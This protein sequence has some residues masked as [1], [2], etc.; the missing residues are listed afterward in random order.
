MPRRHRAL[1]LLPA[2]LA[3]GCADQ[4]LQ[5]DADVRPDLAAV[6]SCGQRTNI[7]AS[8][9]LQCVTL[10]RVRMHQAELQAIADENG[11]M[12]VAGSAGYDASVAYVREQLEGAGYAVTTQ[13]FSFATTFSRTPS[14]LAQVS[15]PANPIAHSVLAYSGSGDHTAS[16]TVP[17]VATGCVAADWAGFPAGNIALVERGGSTNTFTCTFALK[18]ANAHAA[19]ARAVVIYNNTATDVAWTL[20]ADFTLD[21]PVVGVT[22]SSGQQLVATPGLELRVRTD[23]FRGMATASNVLAETST[24]NADNVVVVGAHLDG[25]AAGPGINDNGS[26]VGAVLETAIQMARVKPVNRVRFAF[27]GA[28]ESGLIGSEYYVDNL[29]VQQ[30]NQIALYLNFDVLGSPNH[31]FFIFDGDNSDGAGTGPGPA[32]SDQIEAVFEEY[33]DRLGRPHRGTP[34]NGRSDYA[35]FL[36]AGIPTGGLFSGAEELKT[37]EEAALWGGTAGQPFDP[38]FHQACDTYDNVN[39]DALEINADAV[40]YA[41]LTFALSTE[42]VNGVRGRGSRGSPTVSTTPTTEALA[43]Y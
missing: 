17:N 9:L 21:I 20:G 26:G 5:P 32:G 14:I 22:Q 42:R 31:G 35:A 27:W 3:S 41:T 36:G 18:A 4:P 2:L 43:T 33:F 37:A 25:V 24:G 23:V 34:F 7:T 11:G 16:A 28:E 40:A 10:E 8:S 19:G 12:R 6:A 1:F 38:C 30:R 39:L 29:A 15:P 13:E